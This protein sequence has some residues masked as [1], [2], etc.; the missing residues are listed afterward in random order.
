MVLQWN[1]KSFKLKKNRQ[2]CIIFFILLS[3]LQWGPLRF[4]VEKKAAGA[5]SVRVHCHPGSTAGHST[6]DQRPP[7]GP[8]W[9]TGGSPKG[10]PAPGSGHAGQGVG[11]HTALAQATQ[12]GPFAHCAADNVREPG[13]PLHAAESASGRHQ[14]RP[15]PQ[16]PLSASCVAEKSQ[17]AEPVTEEPRGTTHREG[18]SVPPSPCSP[19]RAEAGGAGVL[20]FAVSSL[21]QSPSPS[22]NTSR[23]GRECLKHSRALSI[24]CVGHLSN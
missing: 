16:L 5:P 1:F 20:G 4:R 19:A 6:P 9:A 14:L 17:V 13:R 3:R 15:S 12:E 7:H 8:S 10:V 18:P 2:S 21:G 23:K 22:S 11:V 24:A